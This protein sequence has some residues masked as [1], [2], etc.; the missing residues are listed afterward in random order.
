MS[1]VIT[2]ATGQLGR[3]VIDQLLAAGVPAGQLVATGRDA[4]RL[5]AL[6]A[7][8]GVTTRRADFADP[9]SLAEAFHG[10]ERLLLVSTTTVGHRFDNHRRA[11][12]AAVA[13]GGSL[14]AYTSVLNAGAARTRLAAEHHSTEQYLRAGAIPFVILRN[15]WY[16]ENYTDQLPAIRQHGV[17]LGAAGNGRVSAAGR[18]DYAAAAAA[19]LTGDGHAGATYELGGAAFTLTE[20]AASF[21]EVLGTPIAYRDLPTDGYAAALAGAGLPAELA[22]VLADAD[23]GLARGELFTDRHDLRDLI[24]RSPTTRLRAIHAAAGAAG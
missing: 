12:D 14:V 11:I 5:S 24:G 15:G 23:A 13:A 10:V 18:V 6:T 2:G 4:G 9:A 19:V 7:R 21:S 17:L 20:L 3:L 1:L 8:T 22:D 16:L